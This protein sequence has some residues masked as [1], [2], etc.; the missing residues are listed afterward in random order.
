MTASRGHDDQPRGDGLALAM[1]A[2]I[3]ASFALPVTFNFPF[4]LG[5]FFAVPAIICGHASRSIDKGRLGRTTGLA[6]TALIISYFSAAVGV[7]ILTLSGISCS[8][9]C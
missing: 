1:A 6:T 5:L 8:A 2:L 4:G 3:L 7:T 9:G